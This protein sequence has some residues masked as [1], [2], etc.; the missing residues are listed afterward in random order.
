MI[1]IEKA[2]QLIRNT[3]GPIRPAQAIKAGIA[4]KPRYK[5]RDQGILATLSRGLYR[6]VDQPLLSNPDFITVSQRLPKAVIC[7]VSALHYY[8]L[9]EQIPYF[10][11]IAL[12]QKS[13]MPRIDHPPLKIIWLSERTYQAGIQ[14]IFIQNHQIKMYSPEKTITDCFKFRNKFGLDVAI[15]ALK[16][17]LEQPVERQNIETLNQYAKLDRVEKI[18]K[19]YLESLL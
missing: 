15:D 14:K 11:Y 18:M 9:T 12:P 19:P 5:M 10:V 13:E 7:L 4:P 17:Y 16:R 3:Q 8:D 2:I 6:L 1:T